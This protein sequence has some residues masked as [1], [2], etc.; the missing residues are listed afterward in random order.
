MQSRITLLSLREPHI[1]VETVRPFQ[2]FY[3]KEIVLY[4]S[5]LRFLVFN[6]KGYEIMF[7]VYRQ[8]RIKEKARNTSKR[9]M[10]G[11]RAVLRKENKTDRKKTWSLSVGNSLLPFKK[12]QP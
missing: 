3:G 7:H 10:D 8:D 6:S 12:T 5:V 1:T 2:V 4:S 9:S 11:K